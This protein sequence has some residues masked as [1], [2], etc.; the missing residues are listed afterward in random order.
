MSRKGR[1]PFE[2]S[3]LGLWRQCN[4]LYQSL[5]LTHI[6]REFRFHPERRWRADV[7]FPALKILCEYHGGLFMGRKGGHQ[8]VRGARND[9]E[10]SNEAQ[11]LGYLFLQFGP[12]ET[13]SGE[14]MNV[15]ARAIESRLE[16]KA[17]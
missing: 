6:E 15:I 12:D 13:R 8:T 16:G 2:A 9:W 3:Q 14:A 7:G 10:K 17:A 5:H 11:L 1:W 4:L